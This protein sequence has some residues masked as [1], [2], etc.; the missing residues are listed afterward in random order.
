MHRSR[1]YAAAWEGSAF[2]PNATT[3]VWAPYAAEWTFFY[4]DRLASRDDTTWSAVKPWERPRMVGWA[5][6]NCRD[7]RAQMFRA[8]KTA[9]GEV[10]VMDGVDALG[11]CEHSRDFSNATAWPPGDLEAWDVYP[12]YRWVIAMENSEESGYVT[13]KLANAL[14]AGAVGIYYGDSVAARKIFK[15]ESF[16]DILRVWRE[17]LPGH[18]PGSAPETEDD[19]LEI[20]RHIVAIDQDQETYKTY[21]VSDV[22][23]AYPENV[24]HAAA[25]YPNEPWPIV[26]RDLGEVGTNPNIAE[27]VTKLRVALA[28]LVR[29]DQEESRA[30]ETTS[31]EAL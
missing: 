15:E 11:N 28:P 14:A 6:G 27:A 26:G 22:L 5:S 21:A 1:H 30:A 7:F 17:T 3:Y 8:L 16:V 20:A 10:G 19:W 13:E 9:A 12:E 2:D 29:R 4:H 18:E 31:G 23:Q 24:K 25:R